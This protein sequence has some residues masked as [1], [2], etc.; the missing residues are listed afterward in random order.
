M[1]Q[2]TF[3]ED[4]SEY[5][6]DLLKLLDL[7]I[8][9]LILIE[10]QE[11][12]KELNPWKGLTIS[13]GEVLE[14]F[15]E[16]VS[17]EIL[18]KVNQIHQDMK[19]LNLKIEE[20][21]IESKH[22]GIEL[23]IQTLI[24]TFQ[25]D[26]VEKEILF[27]GMAVEI[28]A[29]Y[30]KIYGFL[31]DNINKKRA[32][33]DLALRI[34]NLSAKEKIH[35]RNQIRRES[36]LK[37][38]ILKNDPF[39]SEEP[40]FSN[41][42]IIDERIIDYILGN[43][44]IDLSLIDMMSFH[45]YRHLDFE[46][47]GE[48][49]IYENIGITVE[50]FLKD[51]TQYH[52]NLFLYL[53]GDKGVGK[54]HEVQKYCHFI[55]KD[56]IIADLKVLTTKEAP[57]KESI[58]KIIREGVLR[59]AAICFENFHSM[60]ESLEEKDIFLKDFFFMT[61]YFL[62]PIFI[63][64]EKIYE[65]NKYF[66]E[67]TVVAFYLERPTYKIREEL[68]GFYTKKYEVEDLPHKDLAAKFYFTP[69]QIKNA[70]K[71]TKSKLLLNRD[72]ENDVYKSCFEQVDKKLMQKAVKV[73]IG[74][75]WEQLILPKEQKNLLKD[76]CNQV[77]NRYIVYNEWGFD[78]KVAY[79]KGLAIICAGPPGTGKT[80]SAQ[81]MANELNLELYRID[82][83]QMVSKYIGETEKNLHQ[84]FS[85]ASLS[86]AILFFDEADALFGKRSDVKNANDRYANI[87]TSYLLQKIEEY[88]GVTLLATNFLKNI[89]K[90]FLRRINFIINFPFPDQASR[91]KIWE[92]T[93]PKNAP[94]DQEV[95]FEFLAKTFEMAGGNIKNTIIYA[96]FLAAQENEK[97]GM[98]HILFA[99]KYELQKMDKLLLK[100]DLGEYKYL[101]DLYGR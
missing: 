69:L 80:M 33:I 100:E 55:K 4:S 45:E 66:N 13:E 2:K 36:F 65:S 30:E 40:F 38:F 29:K 95:D 84:I 25:L 48:N 50:N 96:A 82:L 70:V 14:I 90:A 43:K 91:Q 22:K 21:F 79:G 8:K 74:Y 58:M 35:F 27:I 51:D 32:S 83:S 31:Q 87:E 54:K 10:N 44:N 75:D 41:E 101:L 47:V 6:I 93:I 53:Y 88:E 72:K 7:K 61:S 94:I 34:L 73:N 49:S 85:Q 56:L 68:W 19:Q 52:N 98:K 99:A 59:E 57:L 46:Y 60:E 3:Y 17:H 26:P 71:A 24:E 16:H 81:V 11:K 63:L 1:E 86:N 39:D 12:S 23:K 28:D 5:L 18:E 89:D 97:I 77:K 37:T 42:I 78:K 15:N 9:R 92:I 64:S 62:E 67:N 76:A 20:K